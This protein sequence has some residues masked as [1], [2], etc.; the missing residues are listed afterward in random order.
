MTISTGF[1]LGFGGI[2]I[3]VTADA[4]TKTASATLLLFFVTGL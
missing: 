2:D 4:A 1:M 3:T